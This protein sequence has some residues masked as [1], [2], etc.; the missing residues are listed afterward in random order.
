MS[1]IPAIAAAKGKRDL[2][3]LVELLPLYPAQAV[4]AL[5]EL[6]DPAVIPLLM[7]SAAKATTV[8]YAEHFWEILKSF[9]DDP[10]VFDS[11]V[12][13]LVG[14]I[15]R[16]Y[17]TQHLDKRSIVR[18]AVKT[19][20]PR[21]ADSLH[22]RALGC[23]EMTVALA[24]MG[25]PRG[26]DQ[27][28]HSLNDERFMGFGPA[29]AEALGNL[30]DPR[31]IE[32]LIATLQ[33]AKKRK[34]RRAVAAALAK[35][36]DPRA[37]AAIQALPVKE[38]EA[39]LP[40]SSEPTL[41]ALRRQPAFQAITSM[42]GSEPLAY[43]SFQHEAPVQ[44]AA[45]FLRAILCPVFGV[46]YWMLFAFIA[47]LLGASDMGM[48]IG[49]VSLGFGFATGH[50]V[51]VHFASHEVAMVP[52]RVYVAVMNDRIHLFDARNDKVG[53][54]IIAWN[55]T[56]LQAAVDTAP[57]NELSITLVTPNGKVPLIGQ[58]YV[59]GNIIG[60]N[61]L[62]RQNPSVEASAALSDPKT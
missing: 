11:I 59:G 13:S 60:V 28:L 33:T 49:V 31:A 12:L 53:A 37:A 36:D 43:G 2:K 18:L 45:A 1:Q 35:F 8:D 44:G 34:L 27:F 55:R 4:T 40:A 54:E 62:L 32:P 3:T 58:P 7:E 50:Q 51:V 46:I 9:R 29:A 6:H 52:N 5:I 57:A 30:R 56:E 42:V 10:V 20:D 19:G 39:A 38:R 16:P 48:V 21:V 41:E 22:K 26:F 25:D 14:H 61:R 23:N 47:G 17:D 24:E 15:D